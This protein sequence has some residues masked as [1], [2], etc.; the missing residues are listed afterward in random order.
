MNSPF[1]RRMRGR[2]CLF[3]LW[4]GYFVCPAG[5]FAQGGGDPL[6]VVHAAVAAELSASKLDHTPWQ[7]RDHDVQPEKDAVYQ[8]I[9]TP[10]GNL[11]RLLEM[12]GQPLKG[13]EAQAELQRVRDFVRDA[14]A[15][16]H[17]KKAADQDEAQA[18]ELLLMLPDAFLWTVSGQ[19]AAEIQLRF[20]PNPA[21]NPPDMQ[22][23]VLGTMAGEMVVARDGN[24]IK[25]LRGTLTQDVRIGFGILGKLE[26]G[27]VFDVERRELA[28]GR[29]QITETHV[30]I[31]GH[32]LLFKTIGEQEDEVKT[33]W[34]P[35]TAPDL[36]AAEEQITR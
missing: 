16:N 20:R 27:G 18:R 8:V 5:G 17:K 19:N 26:K 14:D 32:A 1:Q 25:T 10:K 23:R 36:R 28:P 31:G 4:T 22:S 9:E 12:N 11:R 6:A 3:L 35:A 24:R 34:K 30:H 13:A 15:Q 21:F 2:L 29:W 33:G 7:Y